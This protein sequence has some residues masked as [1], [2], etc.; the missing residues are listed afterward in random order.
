MERLKMNK[1]REILRLR[2]SQ[3]LSVRQTAAATESS[4]GV[5]SKTA[6]R[7]RNAG[8]TWEEVD[9]LDDAALERRLYGGPKGHQGPERPRPDP[10]WI[11]KELRRPGVTLELLHLEYLSEH[12]DGYRY[13]AFCETYRRWRAKTKVSMRQEHKAGEKAFVDYSGKK[14]GIIDPS[15]GEVRKVELFV[16]VL[17]ASSLTF[18]EATLTQQLGDF[19]ASHTRMLKYFGGVPKMLVPDQLKSAVSIPDRY[20]PTINR[21]Y[22]ELG[23]YYDTAIVPARPRRPKDKAKVEVAVQVVQRWIMA[24]LRNEQFFSLDALNDRIRALLEDLNHRPMRDFGGS[25]RRELFEE[26]EQ[27][28]LRTLPD[29][30][31]EVSEWRRAKVAPDYHVTVDHHHYSVPYSL[32]RE[33]VEVRITT[34]TVEVFFRSKRVATHCRSHQKYR[35]TTDPAHMPEAHRSVFEGGRQMRTW[36]EHVGPSTRA[37]VDKIFETQPFEVQGWR[38]VQGLRRLESKYGPA[39]LEMACATALS[40]NGRSYKTVER[41]LKLGREAATDSQDEL[42]TIGHANI[43]GAEYYH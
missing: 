32:H 19:I 28:I 31:F 10:R 41:L 23:R 18:A 14:P 39:R 2:W 7:A 33:E 16:G 26:L 4:T 43:R 21:T 35:H 11:A 17:G 6:N 42:H 5:V 13:T 38:S 27:S 29:K 25:S 20:A 40:L 22:A 30:A 3:E 1:T 34:D 12:P 8:L 36:A 37:L 15:T 24:R 9:G